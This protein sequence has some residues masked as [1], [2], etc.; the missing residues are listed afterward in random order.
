MELSS[1]ANLFDREWSQAQKDA[2]SWWYVAYENIIAVTT[3]LQ[4]APQEL[5]QHI[6]SLLNTIDEFLSS[7][8]LGEYSARLGILRGFEAHLASLGLE[9]KGW[10][11]LQHALANL[12]VCR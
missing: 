9:S 4:D 7:S 11:L 12:A 2:A 3:H 10:L 8:G 1:W 6:R 5:E